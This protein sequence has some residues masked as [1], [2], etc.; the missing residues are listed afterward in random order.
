MLNIVLCEDNFREREILQRYVTNIIQRHD[1]FGNIVLSTE[2]PLD[3]LKYVESSIDKTNIYFLDIKLSG[4]MNGLRLARKIREKDLDGYIVFITAHSELTLL[5]FEYKIRAL[6]FIIKDDY[7][8]IRTR[9]EECFLTIKGEKCKRNNKDTKT[10][11][12]KSGP[13]TYNIQCKDIIFVETGQVNHKVKIHTPNQI[14]EF[15]GSLKD[16]EQQLSDINFY[17]CHRSYLINLSHIKEIDKE[18]LIIKT[19]CG[20]CCYISQRYLK[21]LMERWIS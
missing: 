5:T 3:V 21:G 15:Y 2:D 12:I 6:D 7:E 8:K 13:R 4:G 17:R 9:I 14:I 20:N 19:K 18:K 1:I 11:N 10:I 16:I